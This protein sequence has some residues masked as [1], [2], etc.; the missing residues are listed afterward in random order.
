VPYLNRKLNIA[1]KTGEIPRLPKGDLVRPT[2]VAGINALGRGQDRES[3]G[4]FLQVIARTIGPQAIAQFINTDEVIKR[5]AAASGIDVLNLVKSMD[6]LQAERQQA[7]Q[8]QQ[9]MLQQEQAPQMAA[10]RQKQQQA[11]MQMA[12]QQDDQSVGEAPP[13]QEPPIPPQ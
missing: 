6:E 5:L 7:M 13:P 3:L 4:Q 11:A 8:Q 9:A 10:V 2:I 1:Q 12:Q